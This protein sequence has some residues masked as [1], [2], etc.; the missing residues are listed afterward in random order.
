MPTFIHG[1][2]AALTFDGIDVGAIATDANYSRTVDTAETSVFGTLDKRYVPGM[3]DETLSG[4]AR[5]D[6]ATLQ[7][8]E[9]VFGAETPREVVWMPLGSATGRPRYTFNG[10]LTDLTITSKATLRTELKE[11]R[12]RGYA[13][14]LG[15]RMAGAGSVA[16]PVFGHDGA[17][18]AVISICGPVERFR[19]EAEGAARLL[20]AATDELSQQLG[21][22]PTSRR[23]G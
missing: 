7:S 4:T 8:L 21:Y 18:L 19:A 1:R 11:I 13:K 22:D 14:S 17:P 16:A 10:F 12:A 3:R 23:T 20:V 9:A 15:E 6:Q 2:N 5:F